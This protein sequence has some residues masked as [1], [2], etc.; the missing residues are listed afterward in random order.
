M[1]IVHILREGTYKLPLLGRLSSFC[2]WRG[3][4][5]V[6][7]KI[8]QT[9]QFLN[10]AASC[11]QAHFIWIYPQN[12]CYPPYL[13]FYLWISGSKLVYRTPANCCRSN[14]AASQ[15]ATIWKEIKEQLARSLKK[16]PGFKTVH[17][18]DNWIEHEGHGRMIHT[19]N[20]SV[21][22]VPNLYLNISKTWKK[23]A[24]IQW[25]GQEFLTLETCDKNC[26]CKVHCLPCLKFR[27]QGK[28]KSI[29][30]FQA[31]LRIFI[32][33]VTDNTLYTVCYCY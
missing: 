9:E 4:N 13:C 27:W 10:Y 17:L 29:I 11:A 3:K 12:V 18:S 32:F 7:T 23:S 15:I 20:N 6:R 2:K 19:Q 8:P 26:K 28:Y 5:G 31:L 30:K 14:F 16:V 24:T 22:S 1:S 25:S 33:W 21:I